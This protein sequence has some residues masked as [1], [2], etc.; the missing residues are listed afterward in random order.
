MPVAP[1]ILTDEVEQLNP[2]PFFDLTEEEQDAYLLAASQKVIEQLKTKAP[3]QPSPAGEE[4]FLRDLVACLFQLAGATDNDIDFLFNADP[5]GSR[6]KDL[7]KLVVMLLEAARPDGQLAHDPNLIDAII[8]DC[9]AMGIVGEP[10]LSLSIYTVG[11][12]RLLDSPFHAIVRGSSSGGKS[13]VVETVACLFPP[14][15]VLHA[16][17]ISRQALFYIEGGLTHKFVVLGERKRVNDDD[18]ADSTSALR[19]MQS[20]GKLTQAVSERSKDGK[21]WTAPPREIRGPIASVETT[22]LKP[23]GIF[24]EDL[25]RVLLLQIDESPQQTKRILEHA[26]KQYGPKTESPDRNAIIQKHHAFQLRLKP[27]KVAIPFAEELMRHIPTA[28]IE[29]RRIGKQ[30]L[31]VIEA[32]TVLHQAQREQDT[33]GRLI[34]TQKDYEIARRIL[35]KPLGESLAIPGAPA[36]FY[37]K[38]TERFGKKDFTTTQAQDVD[39]EASESSVK[40]WLK[41]LE[42]FACVEKRQ[43]AKGQ[44]PAVWHVNGKAPENLVLPKRPNDPVAG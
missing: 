9:E 30:I 1:S 15:E 41:D 22:T 38:L 37:D 11:T 28:K 23:E 43:E 31:A 35:V 16:T 40:K 33:A 19:Q 20:E 25:N 26:A 12:S 4:A 32:I 44:S 18:A 13:H 24:K 3:S 39:L 8:A 10:T 42:K 2:D 21:S 6:T 14:T 34:A 7:E 29:A 36:R 17:R 27:Y 5:D